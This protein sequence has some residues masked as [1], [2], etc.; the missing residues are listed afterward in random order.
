MKDASITF[1]G[2]P[3]DVFSY[4]GALLIFVAV[5]LIR[6]ELTHRYCDWLSLC[7]VASL[8]W[9][10]HFS[11]RIIECLWVHRY[12]GRRVP[13]G[14]AIGEYAYYWGFGV[15]NAF[16]L[17]S[18]ANRALDRVGIVGVALFVTGE[19]GNNWAH[20]KLRALRQPGTNERGI[21]RGGLFNWVSCANY[22]Y[23]LLLWTGFCV[24]CRTV[25]SAVYLVGIVGILGSWAR[26]RHLRYHQFFDGKEN[27]QLYPAQRRALIP[28]IM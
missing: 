26:K 12:A 9:C 18:M 21:P 10:C 11:R 1:P 19:L 27:R 6:S 20:R 3:H 16:A 28:F 5:I 24:L 23:E 17:T 2:R 25:A 15:W 4:S 22:T 8:L 7:S 13:I 14:D